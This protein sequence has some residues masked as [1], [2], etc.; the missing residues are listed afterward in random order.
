M[1]QN[2]EVLAY[3]TEITEIKNDQ[4]F[5]MIYDVNVYVNKSLFRSTMPEWP[6]EYT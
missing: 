1:S 4:V 3:K 5:K 2:C 6:L